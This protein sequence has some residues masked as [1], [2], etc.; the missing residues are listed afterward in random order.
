MRQLR[1]STVPMFWC[2]ALCRRD[3]DQPQYRGVDARFKTQQIQL[4]T[5]VMAT[6]DLDKYHKVLNHS[7]PLFETYSG[8]VVQQLGCRT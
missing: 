1:N 5:L 7:A 6:S 4:Q 8:R 3:L 2:A